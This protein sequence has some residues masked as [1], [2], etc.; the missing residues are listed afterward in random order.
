MGFGVG[1]VNVTLQCVCCLSLKRSDD[2]AL[3]CPPIFLDQNSPEAIFPME[4]WELIREFLSMRD[5]QQLDVVHTT[6]MEW[7]L[8]TGRNLYLDNVA[9]AIE[10]F[11]TC[12]PKH[13]SLQVPVGYQHRQKQLPPTAADRVVRPELNVRRAWVV[14]A[15]LCLTNHQLEIRML[16]VAFLKWVATASRVKKHAS[17]VIRCFENQLARTFSHNGTLNITTL[18]QAF[19]SNP[20][21]V[22]SEVPHRLEWRVEH[23]VPNAHPLENE[24]VH[25]LLASLSNQSHCYGTVPFFMPNAWF[26]N[27]QSERTTIAYRLLIV[28]IKHLVDQN[29]PL[30]YTTNGES[31]AVQ[32][33]A[34]FFH[35]DTNHTFD[36][37]PA[38]PSQMINLVMTL[39]LRMG[40]A[41]T[42]ATIAIAIPLELAGRLGNNPTEV[43]C[44]PFALGLCRVIPNNQDDN[45]ECMATIPLHL[46]VNWVSDIN[47]RAYE[48]PPGF[49]QRASDAVYRE[50]ITTTDMLLLG[51]ANTKMHI[52]FNTHEGVFGF[53]IFD[54]VPR[55]EITTKQGEPVAPDYNV[56]IETIM[57]LLKNEHPTWTLSLVPETDDDEWTLDMDDKSRVAILR[58]VAHSV[59]HGAFY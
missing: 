34:F 16:W 27:T 24:N 2:F 55:F 28:G 20:N 11:A 46:L 21:V 29:Q 58:W 30:A 33:P 40:Q 9:S 1:M 48:L 54:G 51:N 10:K 31:D 37:V 12:D 32:P 7:S 49:K 35:I 23:T 19:A 4:I 14:Y 44:S 43:L 18:L 36:I 22:F 5:R 13:T 47:A 52:T 25:K 50:E 39:P 26:S 59:G 41:S 15:A 45:A 6:F 42:E 38:A 53:S 57:Q 8:C 56:K 3:W 17:P